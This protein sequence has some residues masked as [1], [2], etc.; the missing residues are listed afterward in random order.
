MSDAAQVAASMIHAAIAAARPEEFREGMV[1]R[2]DLDVAANSGI[3]CA[4]SAA[5]LD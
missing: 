3:S 1:V 2:N 5:C 4:R